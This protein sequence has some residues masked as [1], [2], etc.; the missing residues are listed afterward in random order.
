MKDK[1]K[2]NVPMTEEKETK[3]TVHLI[4]FLGT[5]EEGFLYLLARAGSLLNK[6][7]LVLDNSKEQKLTKL[8][9][10]DTKEAAFIKAQNLYFGNM[11]AYD[12]KAFALFDHCFIYFGE[13]AATDW[14]KE[15]IEKSDLL[16]I[17]LP[18]DKY[19]VEHLQE[20]LFSDEERTKSFVTDHTIALFLQKLS[21][22][23]HENQILS[24]CGLSEVAERYICDFSLEYAI[25][26]EALRYN[27]IATTKLLKDDL[28]D[29]YKDIIKRIYQLND[30]EVKKVF[31]K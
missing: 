23:V 30:K 6:K 3:Q 27:K 15:Y 17:S 25:G 31:T 9:S 2:K 1:N 26:I 10:C 18:Y 12:E 5:E 29:A 21:K 8:F 13:N 20:V 16:F 22:K 28:A 19:Q 4:S 11:V 14:A 7:I 24:E